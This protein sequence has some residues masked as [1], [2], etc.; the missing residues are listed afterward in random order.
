MW[1]GA[2][3]PSCA[4]ITASFTCWRARV[5]RVVPS[6]VTPPSGKPVVGP[7]S[8][9]HLRSPSVG[10]NTPKHSQQA[11]AKPDAS[12]PRHV[13]FEAF[14]DQPKAEKEVFDTLCPIPLLSGDEDS[15]A[16]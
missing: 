1:V 3:Q 16:F 9:K 7:L 2:I 11:L 15:T 8:E 13:A 12:D 10:K 6:H 4:L 5:R 14:P